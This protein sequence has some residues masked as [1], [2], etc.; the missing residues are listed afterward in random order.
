MRFFIIIFLMST[1]CSTAWADKYYVFIDKSGYV[2]DI[3]DYKNQ[4]KPT[5]AELG[6]YTIPVLDLTEGEIYLL[7]KPQMVGD[8]AVSERENKIDP[9]ILKS[10]KQEKEIAKDIIINAVISSSI[11]P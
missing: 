3:C 2:I 9:A 5:N 11:N 10:I 8:E 1:I 7:T 6:T 4:F